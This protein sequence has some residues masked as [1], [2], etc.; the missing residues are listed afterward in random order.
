[1][2]IRRLRLL[3][4]FL[5]LLTTPLFSQE[6]GDSALMGSIDESNNYTAPGGHY[7]VSIPVLLELGGSVEDSFIVTDFRDSY[8]THILVATL[9][10]DAALRAQLEKTN[11]KDFLSAFFAQQI[12]AEYQRTYPGAKTEAARYINGV[13]D[14]CLFATVLVPGG[15]AF[16]HLL[17]LKEGEAEPMAKRG[18]FLFLKND[19]IFMITIEL[20]ERMLKRDT[21]HKTSDEEDAILRERLMD[22]LGKMTFPTVA[23]PAK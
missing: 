11:K 16:R 1:M 8:G 18:T 3:L 7:R 5:T 21:F 20:Y 2:N 17:F 14:G 12:L 4:S 15:S 23:T 19:R 13:Q 10:M 9:P 22:F 6:E